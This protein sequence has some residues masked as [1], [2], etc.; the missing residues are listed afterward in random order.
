LELK[1]R[2]SKESILN[3]NIINK[4]MNSELKIR[5]TVVTVYTDWEKR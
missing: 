3:T 2:K 4:S 1:I 5:K